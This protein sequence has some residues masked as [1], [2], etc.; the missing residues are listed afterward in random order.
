MACG[1]PLPSRITIAVS[2]HPPKS[3]PAPENWEI[4]QRNGRV[5]IAEHSNRVIKMDAARYGLLLTT[6]YDQDIQHTPLMKLLMLIC[7][8]CRA[9]QDADQEYHVPWSRHF[10]AIIQRKNHFLRSDEQNFAKHSYH[11]LRSV[12]SFHCVR[13]ASNPIRLVL[14]TVTT[15]TAVHGS[16][17]PLYPSSFK[18]A[19]AFTPERSRDLPGGP[20]CTHESS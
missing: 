16:S 9:Q 4:I 19:P 6:C 17:L 20:G 12:F 10:L 13:G 15:S 8:S 11:F 7:E 3:L 5:W 14:D 1:P 18:C 2:H